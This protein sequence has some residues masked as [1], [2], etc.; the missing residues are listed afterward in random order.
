M[1]G[2]LPQLEHLDGLPVL[3]TE[4]V[5]AK[6]QLAIITPSIIAQENAGTTFAHCI[7]YGY[8]ILFTI[9]KESTDTPIERACE[10][11]RQFRQKY[12]K[13]DDKTSPDNAQKSAKFPVSKDG[14]VLNSNQAQVKFKL[15]EEDDAI[16]LTVK[17]P[18]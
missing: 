12:E 8:L 10:I 9:I 17:L 15:M 16:V 4:R 5:Q 13:C 14:R 11:R 2:T 18:K 6:A 7:I 3:H 1:I